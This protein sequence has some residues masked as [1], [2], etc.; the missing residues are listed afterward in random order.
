MRRAELGAH[1]RWL[2]LVPSAMVAPTP[3]SRRGPPCASGPRVRLEIGGEQRHLLVIGPRQAWERRPA[4]GSS[5]GD[6]GSPPGRGSGLEPPPSRF[7]P[8]PT[9]ARFTAAAA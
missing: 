2:S 1:A 8:A 3:R 7:A 4:G 6:P 9:P 5:E